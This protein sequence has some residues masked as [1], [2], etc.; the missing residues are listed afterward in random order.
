MKMNNGE[1]SNV[2]S[3]VVYT[4]GHSNHP[5]TEFLKIIRAYEIQTIIDVRTIPKSRYNPQFS[6]PALK[7]QLVEYGFRYVHM[8]GLGGLRHA[9]KQ[10][11]NKGWKNASFLGFAD[12]MQTRE[13]KE[14]L[15]ELIELARQ[16]RSAIMCAEAVPWRCHRSLIGDALVVRKI[17]VRD[18][19]GEKS[20]K[21][22]KLTE[23]AKVDSQKNITYPEEL[24]RS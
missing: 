24:T 3:V 12:H 9:T 6:D 16:S 10:S 18:I 14:S 15:D 17:P 23:F 7:N 5:F 2:D 4:I 8:K 21:A 22:H 19:I 20:I 13:F 11:V 1:D